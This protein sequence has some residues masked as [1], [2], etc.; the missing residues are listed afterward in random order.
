LCRLLSMA[1]RGRTIMNSCQPCLPM[2]M[3][4]LTWKVQRWC[5][6][7]IIEAGYVTLVKVELCTALFYLKADAHIC[8]YSWSYRAVLHSGI[9]CAV[10]AAFTMLRSIGMVCECPG[11][12]A[13]LSNAICSVCQ[14]AV[15]T[16]ST[17]QSGMAVCV[18]LRR[19][20]CSVSGN[21]GSWYWGLL[22]LTFAQARKEWQ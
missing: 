21:D 15:F 5:T 19:L 22:C 8:N 14:H 4:S 11:P 7:R 10:V 3:R 9:R 13:C 12:M 6:A 16:S 18:A 20:P 2:E 17:Q 1:F